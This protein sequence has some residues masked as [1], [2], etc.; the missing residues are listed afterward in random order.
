[1]LI[2]VMY[3]RKCPDS[4]P[5]KDEIIWEIALNYGWYIYG[6]SAISGQICSVNDAQYFDKS[7]GLIDVRQGIGKFLK[8]LLSMLYMFS[9]CWFP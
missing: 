4:C 6:F 8:E 7:E 9:H 5:W 3:V 1:M 2:I